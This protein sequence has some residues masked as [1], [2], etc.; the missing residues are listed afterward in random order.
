M[1]PFKNIFSPQM[2]DDIA[3]HLGRAAD[4]FDPEIFRQE[5]LRDLERL[6]LK[7]RS[8]QFSMAI[9]AAIDGLFE[10]NVQ[11]MLRA[12]HPATDADISWMNTDETGL[13]GWALMPITTYVARHGLDRPE[14]S[15]EALR[16]MTMRAT[17]EFDVRPFLRD[18]PDLT[19]GIMNIWARDPNVHVRRLASEGSRPRL[20]WG[21]RLQ[22]LGRDPS[23][24]LPI[25]EKLKDDESEYV[26]RSVANN[27][28]DIAKDHPDLVAD[29]AADWLQDASLGR[30]KLI[31]HACRTLIKQ[32]HTGVLAHFGFAPAKLTLSELSLL[33]QTARMGDDLLLELH[34][35]TSARMPQHLMIDYVMHYRRANGGTSAKVFKWTQ[36]T[37]PASGEITLNKVHKLRHVTTRKHYPGLHR[38]EVQINGKIIADGQFDLSLD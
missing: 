22:D 10:D 19:V 18:H 23:P 13:A 31:R 38:V 28:N 37:L 7:Q 30:Q 33:P 27:L 32:G 12:L 6:E 16:Q 29:I 20:P 8:E 26:R 25:L 2:V 15:L 36:K 4:S 21:M 11:A 9:E 1:E 35:T 34:L 24:I 3:T 5:A 14:F 17:A